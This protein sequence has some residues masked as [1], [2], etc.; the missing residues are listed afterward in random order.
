MNISFLDYGYT[1]Y[2]KSHADTINGSIAIG[3]EA[4]RS[5]FKRMWFAETHANP[6]QIGVSPEVHIAHLGALTNRIRIGAG[7]IMMNYRQPYLVLEA[8]RTLECMFPGRVDLGVGSSTS[9]VEL[10]NERFE[11]D[12]SKYFGKVHTLRN[13]MA[14]GTWLTPRGSS[15]EIWILGAT[16]SFSAR[17]AAEHGLPFAASYMGRQAGQ[18]VPL[19]A[20]KLYQDE[21]RP[22]VMKVPYTM[23]GVAALT[24]HSEE[25][26]LQLRTKIHHATEIKKNGVYAPLIPPD[27]LDPREDRVAFLRANGSNFGEFYGEAREV[28]QRLQEIMDKYWIDEVMVSSIC[29]DLDFRIQSVRDLGEAFIH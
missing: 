10:H 19:E 8:F 5:G 18:A 23:L 28:K 1:C 6:T 7:G 9:Y 22:G 15:P 17:Y 3:L 16:P 21:F 27:M 14:T 26:D 12:P 11:I 20:I 24:G 29:Y 4:E 25:L 2:G 13:E